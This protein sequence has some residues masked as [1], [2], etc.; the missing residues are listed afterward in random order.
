[1][2]TLVKQ[3]IYPK[4]GDRKRTMFKKI[5]KIPQRVKRFILTGFFNLTVFTAPLLESNILQH[6]N[7]VFV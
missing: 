2:E 4:A 6:K 5:S 1:M 3:E 7:N